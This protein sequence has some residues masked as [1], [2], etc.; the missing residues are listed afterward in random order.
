MASFTKWRNDATM[1]LNDVKSSLLLGTS[2]IELDQAT[3]LDRQSEPTTVIMDTHVKV[4]DAQNKFVRNPGPQYAGIQTSTN[5]A[6]NKYEE[7][8]QKCLRKLEGTIEVETIE[9][10][11][12]IEVLLKISNGETGLTAYQKAT[13]PQMS[14]GTMTCGL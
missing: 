9:R 13:S 14:L 3:W 7:R 8:K 5:Y 2:D 6:M 1:L 4:Y 10:N 11:R 12:K